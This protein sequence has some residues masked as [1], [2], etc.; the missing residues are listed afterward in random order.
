MTC[1]VDT[2]RCYLLSGR[3]ELAIPS[4]A[5]ASVIA[6]HVYCEK[7]NMRIR[8]MTADGTG[9]FPKGA[10]YWLVTCATEESTS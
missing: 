8:R 4:N 7:G 1:D 6:D 9:D 2:G 5:P 3:D 10:S